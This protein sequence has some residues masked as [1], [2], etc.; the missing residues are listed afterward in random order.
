MNLM[1]FT[2]TEASVQAGSEVVAAGTTTTQES[3]GVD[4]SDTAK[5]SGFGS[6]GVFVLLFAVMYFVM[7]RP[8]QRREKERKKMVAA[9]KSSD[10]VM[11]TS[12]ILGQIIDVKETSL[13]VKIA[14]N[15]K[16]EVVKSAVSQVL[17]K[18]EVPSEIDPAKK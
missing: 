2:L 12:G 10:R 4:G 13:I 17:G 7:I 18:D 6:M 8:Q 11:L 15:T 16:I 14:D 5:G 3:T 9:V 1:L